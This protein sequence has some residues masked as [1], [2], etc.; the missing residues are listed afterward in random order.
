MLPFLELLQSCHRSSG[1]SGG[2]WPMPTWGWGSFL[3]P[4]LHCFSWESGT[5]NQPDQYWVSSYYLGAF[6]FVLASLGAVRAKGRAGLVLGCAVL[7]ALI[8]ALGN[9]GHLYPLVMKLVPGGG[10]VR[11]PVKFVVAATLLLPLLA[12]HGIRWLESTPPPRTPGRNLLVAGLA[13]LAAMGA[14]LIM[15]KLRPLQFDEFSVTVKNS[16]WRGVWLAI[17]L[18]ILWLLVK[19]AKAVRRL[20]FSL[21]LLAVLWLDLSTHAPALTLTAKTSA[22]APYLAMANGAPKFDLGQGRV[23]VTP[24]A[25]K[26]FFNRGLPDAEN[27]FLGKRLGGFANA[28]LLDHQPKVDGLYSL[29]PAWHYDL[30]SAIYN[31]TNPVP[32]ALTDVMAVSHQTSSNDVFSWSARPNARPMVTAGQRPEFLDPTAIKEKVIAGDIDPRTTVLLDPSWRGKTTATNRANVRVKMIQFSA[33]EIDFEV[34]SDAPTWVVI[35]QTWYPAWQA[36]VN[37]APTAI[38]RANHAFQAIEVPAG[39]SNV[40]LA[41]VD[42]KFQ[43]GAAISSLSLLA[44][45]LWWWRSKKTTTAT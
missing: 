36:W 24:E 14:L 7:A 16:L 21:L 13:A 27:D 26:F 15:M 18:A 30:V 31:R 45:L 10:L 19:E 11:Y 32:P 37:R 42:H 23:M 41:Y 40:R 39:A 5:Y 17:A 9:A 20:G 2:V 8:L 12:A 34:T 4:L 28:N 38:A 29:Y 22:L 35:S 44:C 43:A 33:H 6:P 25:K 3:V 1:Y